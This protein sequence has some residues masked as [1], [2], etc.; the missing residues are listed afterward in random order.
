M[1]RMPTKRMFLW[2]LAGALACA[3]ALAAAQVSFGPAGG[4]PN[5][6]MAQWTEFFRKAPRTHGFKGVFVVSMPNVSS[7]ASSRITHVVWRKDVLERIEALTGPQRI[8]YRRNEDAV[9]VYPD[10]KVLR[11]E[12]LDSWGVFP[13]AGAEAFKAASSQYRVVPGARGRIAGYATYRVDFRPVDGWRFGYRVWP[14]AETGL[15]LKLQTLAADG[16]VIEQSEFSE[17]SLDAD[18]NAQ[19]LIKEM[20]RV[21]PG[22]KE[23]RSKTVATTLASEGWQARNLPEGF[24]P[25]TCYKRAGQKSVHGW[26]QCVFSD[27]MASASIFL[28]RYDS[29]RHRQEGEMAMGATHTLVTRSVDANK[30]EWWATV[31]GEVPPATLHAILN[32]MERMPESRNTKN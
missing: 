10:A 24:E 14:H 3:P 6:S 11:H 17:L 22:Y 1:G 19:T 31:V 7:V 4:S 20:K 12:R 8:T 32:A 29:E 18:V 5:W 23:L 15:V 25:V 27:G 21:P 9:T 30:V 28:E 2:R 13:G 16:R 26:L